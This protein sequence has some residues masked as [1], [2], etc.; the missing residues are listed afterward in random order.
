MPRSAKIVALPQPVAATPAPGTAVPV[1]LAD[2]TL[3]PLNPRQEH[4][5]DG[6]AALAQS[7]V[8]LGLL[9][10][11][12]GIREPDGRVAVVAGGRRLA[13]LRLAVATRPDLD[14]VPVLLAPDDETARLWSLAE[15]TARAALPIADEVRAY[16]RMA[17]DGAPLPTIAAAFA[18]TEA[19][20]RRRLKL[21]SLPEPV[22]DALKA[23]RI[24]LGHAQVLTLAT[25]E[26]RQI[27]ALD[28][29]AQRPVSEGVLR[30]V[31]TEERVPADDRQA[32]FVGLAAYEAAGGAVTRDLFSAEDE[33]FL[34]DPALLARLFEARL[35]EAAEAKRAEGWRWIEPRPESYLPWDVGKAMAR[36][37]PLPSPMSDE[38]EAEL[39]G[40][41]ELVEREELTD[42]GHARIEEIEAAR[43][44]TFDEGHRAVAGGWLYVD[45]DGALCEALGFIRPEDRADAIAAGA[46]EAPHVRSGPIDGEDADDAGTATDAEAHGKPPYSAALVADMQAVRLAAVQGALLDRLDLV[47]DLLAFAVSP[48]SGWGT[49]PLD[50]R[51]GAQPVTPAEADGFAPD[52]RLTERPPTSYGPED[53]LAAFEAFRARGPEHRD[54]NLAQAF[55]R[56]LRYGGGVHDRSRGL[57]QAVEREAG[58][59]L[60][61]VWRPT[62]ANF[63]GRVRSETLEALFR[64]LLDRAPDDPGFKAFKGM[65]KG[66]KV[67]ALDRLFADP[68]AASDWIVTPEQ[69]ARIRAWVPPC[70]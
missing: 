58:A 52:P 19:H 70:A 11:L 26:A 10:N 56:T 64:D 39:A 43:P 41:Y 27:E 37:Y 68:A 44:A 12:A 33:A 5:P 17:V 28:L 23:G 18:V 49:G 40:L 4:D 60:R 21:A 36:V 2:L 32:L 22:L 35:A 8:T 61:A 3:S 16:R 14:P 46:I 55:A 31:L 15:N 7:L 25:D 30:R 54:A 38:E 47:L 34:D 45:R 24:S 29:L 20:V 42:E 59:D 1:P 51:T 50:L 48:E 13:A 67:A 53:L 9:Q 63:L 6:I 66:E 57:F 62:S 69:Q 65:K